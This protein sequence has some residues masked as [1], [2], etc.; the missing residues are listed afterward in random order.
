MRVKARSMVEFERNPR[1]N[2]ATSS[3]KSGFKTSG[4]DHCLPDS[5]QKAIAGHRNESEEHQ[6][7]T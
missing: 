3:R 6:T 1:G 7:Q 5:L 4:F 2:Y